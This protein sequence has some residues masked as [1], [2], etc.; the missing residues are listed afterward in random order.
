MGK[1]S[2]RQ[3]VYVY[4]YLYTFSLC[5]HSI[6]NVDCCAFILIEDFC[7]LS[8]WEK[9]GRLCEQIETDEN[10]SLQHHSHPIASFPLPLS[11]YLCTFLPQMLIVSAVS[12][13]QL[14]VSL[15]SIRQSRMDKIYKIRNKVSSFAFLQR[16][17]GSKEFE[18][19]NEMIWRYVHFQI[20]C[21]KSSSLF[22]CRNEFRNG[23]V[24]W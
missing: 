5:V 3:F 1:W 17:F 10:S 7:T 16:V 9:H 13:F 18:R 22:S 19:Q 20:V 15:D 21:L 8:L 23:L 11:L 2:K 4:V 24:I 12:Q 14:P 6:V